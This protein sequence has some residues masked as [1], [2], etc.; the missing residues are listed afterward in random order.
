MESLT[1]EE[2]WAIKETMGEAVDI[3]GIVSEMKRGDMVDILKK[4]YTEFKNLH[5]VVKRSVLDS[6]VKYGFRII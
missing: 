3:K 6:K 2:V 1:A 4:V 5:R